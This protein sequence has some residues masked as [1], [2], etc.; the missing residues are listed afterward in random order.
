MS[1]SVGTVAWT[2]APAARPFHMLASLQDWDAGENL[3]AVLPVLN[4]DLR[5]TFWQGYHAM[6]FL[7]AHLQDQRRGDGPG[8][9]AAP[10]ER[11]PHPGQRELL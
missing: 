5:E 6:T 1:G 4:A 9:H 10:A 3:R 2:W 7:P 11:I 8:R